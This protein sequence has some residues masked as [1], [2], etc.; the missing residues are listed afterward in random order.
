MLLWL[1]SA[2]PWPMPKPRRGDV[3]ALDSPY[4]FTPDLA[5]TTPACG[6][7]GRAR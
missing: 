6:G 4:R 5:A 3:N 1:A 7:T 2:P